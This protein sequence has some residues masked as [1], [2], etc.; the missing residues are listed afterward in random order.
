MRVELLSAVMHRGVVLERGRTADLDDDVA[1][2]LIGRGLARAAVQAGASALSED[3]PRP[4][5]APDAAP[6]EG[7]ARGGRRRRST[8]DT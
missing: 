2:S 6:P 8:D 4:D 7:H 3:L 1:A 5:A